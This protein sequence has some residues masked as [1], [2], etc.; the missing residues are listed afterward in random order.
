MQNEAF[1]NIAI[2]K[3]R[4]LTILMLQYFQDVLDRTHKGWMP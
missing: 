1:L 4:L 3:K 2:D